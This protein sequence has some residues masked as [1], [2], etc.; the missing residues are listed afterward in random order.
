MI[1]FLVFWPKGALKHELIP[2]ETILHMFN[3]VSE[4]TTNM[5]FL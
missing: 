1:I 4:R 2:Y 3:S 5:E